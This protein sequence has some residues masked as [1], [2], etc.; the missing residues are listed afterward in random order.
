MCTIYIRMHCGGREGQR[1]VTNSC[2][3]IGIGTVLRYEGGG[4]GKNLEK[5]HTYFVHASLG[6][7]G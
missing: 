6:T 4:V 1:F 7:L 3:N 5:L 2:K